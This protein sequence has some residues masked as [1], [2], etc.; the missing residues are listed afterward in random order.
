MST[1]TEKGYVIHP[2]VEI[3]YYDRVDRD[4]GWLYKRVVPTEDIAEYSHNLSLEKF[5]THNLQKYS[6]GVFY[7][8]DLLRGKKNP[9]S[10]VWRGQ[11][12]LPKKK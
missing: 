7:M 2:S 4:N 3:I 6:N 5:F 9:E 10:G 11:V 8:I 12:F 1:P